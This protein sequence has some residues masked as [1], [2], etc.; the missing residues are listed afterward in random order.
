MSIHFMIGMIGV[1]LLV[2]VVSFFGWS[3]FKVKVFGVITVE[4]DKRQ[5]E[6]IEETKMKR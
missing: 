2:I 3:R 6:T 1:I 4:L 5:D